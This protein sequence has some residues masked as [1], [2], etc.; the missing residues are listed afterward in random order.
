MVH[1]IALTI[2]PTMNCNM[3]CRHCFNGDDLNSSGLLDIEKA[4]WFIEAACKEYQDVKV[5]F[6]G[7]E[8]TLA[9]LDYYKRIYAFQGQMREKY[10]VSFSNN[11]TT[12]AVLLNDELIDCLISNNALINISFDG[13]YNDYLRG[14]ADVSV[15]KKY[16]TA[17]NIN[18]VGESGGEISITFI[19]KDGKVLVDSISKK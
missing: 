3:R 1:E 15:I 14:N 9:G 7:G 8:P 6:H 2:K 12:N 17:D 13:P 11:Y 10:K 16:I 4:F 19:E 18:E 5:T